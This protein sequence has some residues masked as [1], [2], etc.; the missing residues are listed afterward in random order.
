MQLPLQTYLYS[1]TEAVVVQSR[2]HEPCSVY[3]FASFYVRQKKF[4]YFRAIVAPDR[5][6]ATDGD[7][8]LYTVTE[9][10]MCYSSVKLTLQSRD[11]FLI[12]RV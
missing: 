9:P 2:L 4:M 8:V 6:S 7:A 3:Y 1:A 12:T 11:V 5:G 10:V